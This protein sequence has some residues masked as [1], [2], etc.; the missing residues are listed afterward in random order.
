M[1]SLASAVRAPVKETDVLAAA[2]GDAHAFGRLVEASKS[3]V[4]SISLAIVRN[5]G[6]SEDVAQEA[7]LEAW[8]GLARLKNPASFLP[9]LRQLTRHRARNFLR[10]QRRR[11]RRDL[12][13]EEEILESVVDPSPSVA[14]ALETREA[15]HRLARVLDE[16]PDEAREV[17]TLFYREGQSTRQVSELLGLSEAAVRQ[18]LTRARRAIREELLEKA[19]EDLVRTAP[20]PVFSAG[21]AAAVSAALPAASALGASASAKVGGSLAAKAGA[22]LASI[23][24]PTGLLVGINEFNFRRIAAGS[25]DEE[26]AEGFR[27]LRWTSLVFFVLIGVTFPLSFQLVP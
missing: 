18:R 12:S 14:E 6:E 13:V 22:L 1:S 16:L 3:T 24:V 2:S 21:V 4:C 27:R 8:K 26:E 11:R 7:Y 9:W 15:D 5:V 25:L 10:S 20:S 19:G 17:I 23:L